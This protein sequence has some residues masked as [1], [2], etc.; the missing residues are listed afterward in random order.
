M[1]KIKFLMLVI[2]MVISGPATPQNTWISTNGPYGGKISSIMISM[3]GDIYVGTMYGG[4][5]RLTR[6]WNL[7]ENLGLTS[8]TITSMRMDS[9]GTL[10]VGTQG[11]GIF[12]SDDQ[13]KTWLNINQGLQ[14]LIV[15]SMTIDSKD[16]IFAATAKGVFRSVNQG[17]SWLLVSNGLPQ[18]FTSIFTSI[19]ANSVDTLFVGTSDNGVFRS[20]DF[21]NSWQKIKAPAE[22]LSVQTLV[23]Q[24]DSIL[25]VGSSNFGLLRW[26]R[27][28]DSLLVI[29]LENKK[30]SALALNS[31]GHIFVGLNSHH[32]GVIWRSVN[33]GETW[34]R[35]TQGFPLHDPVGSLV[36]DPQDRIFVGKLG[37]GL[38]I[39]EDNGDHW[40]LFGVP[41]TTTT[42]LLGTPDGDI[43]AGD[44]SSFPVFNMYDQ[45]IFRLAPNANLWQEISGFTFN[46]IS[47]LLNKSGDIF[48]G[49]YKS[50]LFRSKDNFRTWEAIN[51]GLTDNVI[52]DIAIN[53][54][55]HLF[56]GTQGG[57]VFRSTNNGDSWSHISQGLPSTILSIA[58]D[59]KDRIFI[60]TF[61][62]GIFRSDDQGDNWTNIASIIFPVVSL[63]TVSD[64]LILAGASGGGMFLSSDAGNSWQQINNG[65]A[66][67]FVSCII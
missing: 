67:R 29:A 3:D 23:T 35:I 53:A 17:Q 25:L 62:R 18:S 38:F 16:R 37:T 20:N 41:N 58:I 39:S 66:N 50:G 55:G 13:G 48:A 6:E 28:Q 52:F 60:G 40:Q 27:N 1:Q 19:V 4:I 33:N 54:Q 30:I 32:S 15:L 47:F 56:V 7:W 36:I 64:R 8:Q 65:L 12:K 10:F 59:S 21:G 61:N 22:N 2:L 34:E 46:V 11:G 63:L 51:I 24:A 49:T 9:K 14:N 31:K 26:D 42:A 5:F 45:G 44:N 57:G 43:L